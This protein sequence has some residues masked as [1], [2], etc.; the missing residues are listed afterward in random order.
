GGGGEGGYRGAGERGGG[1]LGRGRRPPARN[2]RGERRLGDPQRAPLR[3]G[4]A[5]ARVLGFARRDQPDGRDRHGPARGR[6]RV[7]PGGRRALRLLAGGGAR[8]QHQRP[9]L[10]RRPAGGG[11]GDHTRGDG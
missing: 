4:G 1:T 3:R 6:D 9:R 8:S 5:A 7:E 11:R 2:D 10:R